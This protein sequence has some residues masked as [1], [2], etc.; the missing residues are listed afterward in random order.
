[1][2]TLLAKDLRLSLDALRPWGLLLLAAVGVAAIGV[3]ISGPAE[4]RALSAEARF[5]TELA[6]C[7]TLTSGVV[8]AWI[9]ACVLHGEQRHRADAFTGALP[10]GRTRRALTKV[11]AIV[12]ATLLPAALAVGLQLVRDPSWSMTLVVPD[13]GRSWAVPAVTSLAGLAFAVAIA[14]LSRRIVE[15]VGL[16]MIVTVAFGLLAAGAGAVTFT[17]ASARAVR[18]LG[19]DAEVLRTAGE[20][21]V[22]AAVGVGIACAAVMAL[23][24]GARQ[25]ARGERRQR[26]VPY[27]LTLIAMTAAAAT[28]GGAIAMVSVGANDAWLRRAVR[29]A[30]QP[31]L[32]RMAD[33]AAIARLLDAWNAGAASGGQN[34]LL[35]GSG[36]L[37]SASMD[38]EGILQWLT[39]RDA[40]NRLQDP[41]VREAVRR[42]NRM[43]TAQHAHT[44]LWLRSVTAPFNDP[45]VEAL[46]LDAIAAF[47]RQT[48]FLVDWTSDHLPPEAL[49][50][51]W[52]EGGNERAIL[53]RALELL[54]E[55]TPRDDDDAAR[56][57]RAIDALRKAWHLPEATSRD[58]AG[59]D[60]R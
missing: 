38:G 49:P 9:A 11:L 53:T 1:M 18:L 57:R 12:A 37:A 13:L 31:A 52:A 42:L 46:R 29:E 51:G 28:T 50:R 6:K 8:A 10:L 32:L 35:L 34:E 25:L 26:R 2:N 5:L 47:P 17:V 14:P 30:E 44:V 58:E 36:D 43:D 20:R 41:I 24:L 23:L 39:H 55:R 48:G 27:A 19:P 22:G 15:T 45:A 59:E 33:A 54:D 56:T 16:A 21:G 4:M 7:L 3:A 60:V 40:G